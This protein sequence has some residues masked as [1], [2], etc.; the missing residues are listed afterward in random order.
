M[1]P[2]SPLTLSTLIPTLAEQP[3]E[4]RAHINAGLR[5]VIGV[6]FGR[7]PAAHGIQQPPHLGVEVREALGPCMLGPPRGMRLGF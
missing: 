2:H 4:L 7:A 3:P 5:P 6:V 1:P